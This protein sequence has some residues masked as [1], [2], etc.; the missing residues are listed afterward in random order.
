MKAQ[1]NWI[2]IADGNQ[3]RIFENNGVGKGLRQIDHVEQ[4]PKSATE[5]MA[6]KP[7]RSFSSVGQGRSAMEPPTD[8]V[9]KREADFMRALA[10][11]LDDGA[12]DGAFDRLVL[13]AAPRA[14]GDIRQ[15]LSDHVRETL[16]AELP[17]DLANVPTDKLADHLKDI[18]VV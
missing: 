2:V 11:R 16:I 9:Q 14:L 7:G 10:E 18:L 13:A 12:R 17:K 5:I 6:D 1:T 8:P 15:A 4:T 3:A